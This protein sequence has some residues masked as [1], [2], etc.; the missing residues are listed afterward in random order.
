VR[1]AHGFSD[2][3]TEQS[4]ITLTQPVH[5]TFHCRFTK[6][7]YFSKCC[8]RYV[9][10]LGRETTTQDIED[11][12][13]A[14]LFALVAQ[15]PQGALNHRRRPAHIKNSFRRPVVRFLLWNR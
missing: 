5:K 3:F 7:E 15:P 8:I 1:F 11:A 2:F 9:L 6:P 13:S 14:A 10:T 4:A 12:S